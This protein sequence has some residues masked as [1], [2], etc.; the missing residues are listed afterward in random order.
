MEEN[1]PSSIDIDDES[2]LSSIFKESFS[3]DQRANPDF[4]FY[5]SKL[6]SYGI[7]KLNQE[8]E[9]LR[10]NKASVLEQTLDLAFHNY[11]TFIRTAE[12]S[13]DIF[14]DFSIVEDKLQSMIEKLPKVSEH[15]Q[16]FLKEAADINTV[17]HANSLTLVRHT[18]ILEIL[19]IPQLMD[20]CVRNQYYEDALELLF[21]VK[22]LAKK[23]FIAE[24]PVVAGIVKD[25]Q[26][27]A[28]LMLDQLLG[29]LRT[30]I[31]LPACLRIVGFLRRLECFTETELR[32]KFLQAR[33]TW[34]ENILSTIP[35]CS[36]ENDAYE[37]ITRTI[38]VCRVHLFDIVT[39]YRAI[40]SDDSTVMYGGEG[41]I[42]ENSPFESS[43][44]HC[45]L[46]HRINIFIKV[47]ERCLDVGVGTRLDSVL[48]QCMYFGQSFSRV[49]A[50]FRCLLIPIFEQFVADAFAK[51]V[52]EAT[53]EFEQSMAS[54]CLI[55][56][57]ISSSK[58]AVSG[59]SMSVGVSGGATPPQPPIGLLD[60]PPLAVY[61]NGIL[62]SFNNIRLC[63]P[64]SMAVKMPRILSSSIDSVTDAILAFY[65]SEEPAMSE[66][67]KKVFARFCLAFVD[68]VVPHMNA[69]VQ[70][71][72][73]HR[74][75]ANMYGSLAS[76]FENLKDSAGAVSAKTA[77]EKLSDFLPSKVVEFTIADHYEPDELDGSA[78]VGTSPHSSLQRAEEKSTD[79]KLNETIRTSGNDALLGDSGVQ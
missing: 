6:C 49:G 41:S 13:K 11:K 28:Q 44:F 40:F 75:V 46:M 59:E 57:A 30:T 69:C 48:G 66:S 71:L 38:E 31:Q 2:V 27:S 4:T 23:S 18:E 34:L 26:Q 24:I 54:Y 32:L 29:Q 22:R 19:E 33:N 12:C 55:A 21:Y 74:A 78:T 42:S 50:D 61:L 52:R 3:E 58:A 79:Q 35:D 43:V 10:D 65:Q 70:L 76:S 60:F 47:L 67:E 72:L 9:C 51:A 36:S 39:Q 16:A 17:R 20:T 5:L 25:I 45:W 37:L 62:T 73:Q 14:Q 1:Y 64:L 56:T 15:G 77:N 53:A 63:C 68:D 8:P 7:Q